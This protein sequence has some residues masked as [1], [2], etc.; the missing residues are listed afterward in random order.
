V[1]PSLAVE[2]RRETAQSRALGRVVEALDLAGY[3]SLAAFA[4]RRPDLIGLS[5]VRDRLV[6]MI[7]ITST[8]HARACAEALAE[9]EAAMGLA[10]VAS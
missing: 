10:E 8:E 6:A 4:A 9:V 1:S 2:D 7:G 3:Y 5:A